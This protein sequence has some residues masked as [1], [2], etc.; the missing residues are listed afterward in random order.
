MVR[1][2]RAGSLAAPFGTAARNRLLFHNRGTEA[3]DFA[4]DVAPFA[5]RCRYV[6]AWLISYRPFFQIS[7][8]DE[9]EA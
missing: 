5:E 4:K 6:A 2:Y 1:T 3:P 9:A 8:I 7:Q